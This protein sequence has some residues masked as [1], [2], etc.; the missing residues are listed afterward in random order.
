MISRTEELILL[1]LLDGPKSGAEIIMVVAPERCPKQKGGRIQH[2]EEWDKKLKRKL[3]MSV[4]SN[5]FRK[6]GKSAYMRNLE[7]CNLI[8]KIEGKGR[9][10]NRYDV[11]WLR[12]SQLLWEEIPG[13]KAFPNLSELEEVLARRMEKNRGLLFNMDAYRE[14]YRIDGRDNFPSLRG[15]IHTAMGYA[16]VLK[17]SL[18]LQEHKASL[19]LKEILSKLERVSLEANVRFLV[20]RVWKEITGGLDREFEK[21]ELKF[22]EEQIKKAKEKKY[23]MLKKGVGPGFY[24]Y[25]RWIEGSITHREGKTV[26][27]DYAGKEWVEILEDVTTNKVRGSISYSYYKPL[28]RGIKIPITKEE[29]RE[30]EDNRKIHKILNKK[31]ANINELIEKGYEL[32]F[33]EDKVIVFRIKSKKNYE[34]FKS[35]FDLEDFEVWVDLK[36]IFA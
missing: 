3:T 26:D 6:T 21:R 35:P 2:P 13:A 4:M 12:L 24:F 25:L 32:Y 7:D 9:M 15:F 16:Y 19:S 10:E 1:S 17:K 8:K 30:L 20:R 28:S 33:Y 22:I 23:D 36:N 11:N 18:S 31:E 29:K 34:F 27:N 14:L 5:W